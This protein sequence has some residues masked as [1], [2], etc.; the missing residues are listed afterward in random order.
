[1]FCI[2]GKFLY[3]GTFI[4]LVNPLLQIS[5]RSVELTD[6]IRGFSKRLYQRLGTILPTILNVHLIFFL[7]NHTKLHKRFYIKQKYLTE[8]TV[9]LVNL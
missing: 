5:H 3:S 7:L 6:N 8:V 4:T 2:C 1:M 9:T